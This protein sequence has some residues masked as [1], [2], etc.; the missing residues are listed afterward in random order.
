MGYPEVLL[1]QRSRGGATG[2][3]F[4]RGHPVG[5]YVADF[6]R[7]VARRV[8]AVDGEIHAQPATQRHDR[9]RNHFPEDDGDRVMPI[10][11]ANIVRNA[12]SVAT[13][14]D[15]LVATPLHHP[16]DGPPPRAGEDQE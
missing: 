13:A 6:Y 11:A 1:E 4:R 9:S 3:R 7:P 12:D 8:I 16:A 10:T 2:L 14:I 5:P 15:S